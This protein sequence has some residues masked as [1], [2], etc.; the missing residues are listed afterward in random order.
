MLVIWLPN[1]VISPAS[2]RNK[3]AAI[4]SVQYSALMLFMVLVGGLGTFEG[5]IV[6]AL[7]LWVIQTEFIDNGTVYLTGLGVTAIV[8]ALFFPRGLWGV[9]DRLGIRLLP[10]GYRVVPRARR[11]EAGT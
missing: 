4:F 8:V 10:V 7:I 11:E 6:G 3:P 2:G 9:V 1:T 5:P